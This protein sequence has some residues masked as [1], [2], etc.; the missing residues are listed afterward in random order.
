M[1]TTACHV[2]GAPATQLCSKCMINS[3]C[4]RE[5]QRADWP[6][7][8]PLCLDRNAAARAKSAISAVVNNTI[9]YD[10]LTALVRRGN[11]LN[12]EVIVAA[13]GEYRV[14]V[15]L[16]SGAATPLTLESA[17]DDD[18]I[19]RAQFENFPVGGRDRYGKVVFPLTISIDADGSSVDTGDTLIML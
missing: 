7:H 5:C 10:F 11:K 12:A 2:C 6:A 13:P 1:S 8:K 9:V 3:Y 18:D 14:K 19:V 4:S 17:V 16:A 15:K